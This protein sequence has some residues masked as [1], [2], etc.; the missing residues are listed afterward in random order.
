MKESGVLQTICDL[1]SRGETARRFLEAVSGRENSLPWFAGRGNKQILA[2][3]YDKAGD[4]DYTLRWLEDAKDVKDII[5]VM[6]TTW[7]N[8]YSNLER[9][10]QTVWGGGKSP[11]PVAADYYVNSPNASTWLFK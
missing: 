10:A 1:F 11:D 5:G 9:F 6:Y 4:I 8:D 2:G 7:A 3:Y